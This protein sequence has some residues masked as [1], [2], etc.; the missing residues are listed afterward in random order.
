MD[1]GDELQA[2]RI[3]ARIAP[4]SRRN[5]TPDDITSLQRA[6]LVRLIFG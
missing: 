4:I 3:T 6:P 5:R 2:P 1:G